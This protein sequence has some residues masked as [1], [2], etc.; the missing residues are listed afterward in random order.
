MRFLKQ[1][2]LNNKKVAVF[3]T[4]EGSPGNPFPDFK[5]QTGKAAIPGAFDM[6]KPPQESENEAG[7]SL[8]NW[9]KKLST[10][11]NAGN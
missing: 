11:T 3:C 4:R 7:K 2:D 6:D 9:L 10:N 1:A 8:G 5:K